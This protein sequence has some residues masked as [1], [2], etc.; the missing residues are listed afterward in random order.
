M[1]SQNEAPETQSEVTLQSALNQIMV[2]TMILVIGLTFGALFTYSEIKQSIE[3]KSVEESLVKTSERQIENIVPSFL[4]PELKSSVSVLLERYKEDEGLTK[5][6]IIDSERKIPD[7]FKDCKTSSSSSIC[8]NSDKSII[9][10]LVPIK[11]GDRIFGHLLKAKKIQNVLA[12]DHTLQMIEAAAGALILFSML[13]FVFLS[14]ITSKKVPNDLNDLVTWLESVLEGRTTAHAPRLRFQELNKLGTKIGELLDRH[15][16]S[17]DRAMIGLLASGVMHDIKTPIHSLVTAQL[18]VAEQTNN[19]EKRMKY[20]ENLFKVCTNKLP[21]IGAIIET[22]LDGSREIHVEIKP[23]D[24][25]ETI[26]KSVALY[27][28]MIQQREIRIETPTITSPFVV[29]HDPIQLGR[30]IA[31]LVKN[32]IEALNDQKNTRAQSEKDISIQIDTS[33]VGMTKLILEDSGPGLPENAESVFRLL[34]GT[35]PRSSGLGLVVSRKIIQAHE[36]TLTAT[37]AQVL[38]GARFEIRIPNT[39]NPAVKNIGESA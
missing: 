25:Q 6:E 30:V 10:A 31:N 32:S 8:L 1:I 20:L 18:L 36:G 27:S 38:P 29:N 23:N 19:P 2:I 16:R 37:H 9:A 26:S 14:R 5:I 7:D 33:E 17:R 11:V 21:V 22:T 35:K 15:E 28:N 34:R 24:L 13:F 39:I 3:A 12:H 4:V